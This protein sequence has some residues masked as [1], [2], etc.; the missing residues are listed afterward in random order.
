VIKKRERL[1]Q[2]DES[3]DL[4]SEWWSWWRGRKRR[5][6]CTCHARLETQGHMEMTI[7]YVEGIG[8]SSVNGKWRK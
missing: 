1:Q 4:G 7:T 6:S 5:D 3:E 2:Q 8:T